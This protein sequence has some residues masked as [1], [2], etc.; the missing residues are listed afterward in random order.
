MNMSF[1]AD[2]IIEG[3]RLSREDDRALAALID[4][5]LAELCD[6]AD[7]IRARYAGEKVEL[8]AIV[9]GKGGK[10]AENCKFCAQAARYSTG[11]EEFGLISEDEMVEACLANEKEGVDRF[12]V[13]TSGRTLNGRDFENMLH[14]YGLMDRKSTIDLCASF[15]FLSDEQFRLLRIAGA[16]TYHHNLETSRRFF[17]E[18]CTTHTYDMRVRTL[19]SARN[20]GMR[21]CSGGIIGMGETWEDRVD[22]ALELAGLKVD[23]IPINALMPVKGTPLADRPRLSEE[24]I[25]RTVAMFRYLNPT[26]QIRLAAGRGLMENDG[27]KAFRAGASAAITGNMLTTAAHATVKSDR[28]MLTSLGRTVRKLF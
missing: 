8:C 3:R 28:E 12:A 9:S 4:C 26:A 14:A 6:G 16:S 27:E 10:C 5:D 24:D 21:L 22:L 2:T 7:R 25:L 18:I 15:R 17:P 1:M 20:A 19:R 11:C 13:V 23:S